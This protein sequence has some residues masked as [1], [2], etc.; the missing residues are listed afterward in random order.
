L[1]VNRGFI[2]EAKKYHEALEILEGS[3]EL[4]EKANKGK[5]TMEQYSTKIRRAK[6]Q[7]E[8]VEIFFRELSEI[9]KQKK[10][11]K[12]LSQILLNN[13]RMLKSAFL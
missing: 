13:E 2:R 5:I 12:D 3:K 7:K 8:E 1:A 9:I 4:L 10:G 6:E 11:K